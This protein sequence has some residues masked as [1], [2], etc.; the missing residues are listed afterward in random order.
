MFL[1][2]SLCMHLHLAPESRIGNRD[3]LLKV[4]NI[5]TGTTTSNN[6]TTTVLTQLTITCSKLITETLEKGVIYIQS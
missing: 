3:D 4:S 1:L 5:N 2:I 6:Q